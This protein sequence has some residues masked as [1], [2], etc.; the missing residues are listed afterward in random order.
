M[1]FS[2]LKICAGDSGQDACRGDSGGPLM[3]KE[4]GVWVL[5]RHWVLCLVLSEIRWS[6]R[7]FAFA[8]LELLV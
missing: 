6:K 4:D 2:L 5:V 7:H 8:L 1:F 3:A